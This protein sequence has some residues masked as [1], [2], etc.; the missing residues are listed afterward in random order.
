MAVSDGAVLRPA[1]HEE[2]Q[3]LWEHLGTSFRLTRWRE[4][5]RSTQIQAE[6]PQEFGL[7]VRL[8][9]FAFRRA[10]YGHETKPLVECSARAI[11]LAA[12]IRLHDRSIAERRHCANDDRNL[13]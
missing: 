1:E 9:R 2:F 10:R 13:K 7:L 12:D 6:D 5:K 11:N 3:H 8:I 4:I